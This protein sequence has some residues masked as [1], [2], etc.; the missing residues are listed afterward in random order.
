MRGV[1]PGGV[2]LAPADGALDGAFGGRGAPGEELAAQ[3]GGRQAG[4]VV[5]VAEHAGQQRGQVTA[6]GVGTAKQDD[7]VAAQGS[8]VRVGDH[9]DSAAGLDGGA[10]EFVAR[11]PA[12]VEH[13]RAGA[14]GDGVDGEVAV[15][16]GRQLFPGGI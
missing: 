6:K 16:L 7:E 3:V 12:L 4:L 2:D 5:V 10:Q 11:L 1:R 13:G 9:A 8:G 14:G 15:A